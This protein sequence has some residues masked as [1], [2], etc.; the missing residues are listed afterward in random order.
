MSLSQ[1]TAGG[2]RQVSGQGVFGDGEADR[3][4]QRIAK[5]GRGGG[6]AQQDGGQ[7][8]GGQNLSL[9]L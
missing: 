2:Q 1:R 7:G 5:G 4:D 9:R 6:Q 3:L 8:A